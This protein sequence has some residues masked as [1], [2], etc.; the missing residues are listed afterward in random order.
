M[1]IIQ[2]DGGAGRCLCA[3]RALENLYATT[4]EKVTIITAWPEVFLNAP[5]INKLYNLNQVPYLFDDIV[6]HGEFINPEPYH[7][8]HYYNQRHNLAQSFDFLI[9]G[10]VSISPKP[11][12]YLSRDE[13]A[14]GQDIVKQVKQASGKT[15][16]VALQG[17]GAGAKVLETGELVD[18]S[19]RSLNRTTMDIILNRQDCVYVNLSHIPMNHPNIWSQPELNIRRIMAIASACDIAVTIDSLL[20]HIVCALDK[21]TLLLLGP[22]FKENVGY[23]HIKTIQR[24]GYPKSYFPNRFHGFVDNNKGA[25]DFTDEENKDISNAILELLSVP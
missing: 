12:I 11:T 18:E 13:I 24:D 22:T 9:N 19:N 10:E 14:F 20:S 25:M 6:K 3:T 8:F 2:I 15:K 7:N 17:F 5:Y 16:V 4:G 21:P 23:T 1:K